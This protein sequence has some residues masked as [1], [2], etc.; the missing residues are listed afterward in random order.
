[1][2]KESRELQWSPRYLLGLTLAIGGCNG[3][4]WLDG[5]WLIGTGV[6]YLL[7]LAISWYREGQS[8]LRWIAILLPLVIFGAVFTVA[9]DHAVRTPVI[10][11][12][13]N[14]FEGVAYVFLK[15]KCG[16]PAQKKDQTREYMLPES[17]ILFS[18]HGKNFGTILSDDLF[19][20]RQTGGTS[21]RLPVLTVQSPDTMHGVFPGEMTEV[22]LPDE[23]KAYMEYC[24]VGTRAQWQLFM[25]DKGM[26]SAAER[27][28][29]TALEKHRAACKK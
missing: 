27:T 29:I 18:R 17:G 5:Y 11:T 16:D 14:G 25:G 6:V 19:F 15:E 4:H 22:T 1:M 7:G 9:K 26:S 10:W 28:A 13:P 3:V 24:F 2:N 21:R 12:F 8:V 20:V 23:S